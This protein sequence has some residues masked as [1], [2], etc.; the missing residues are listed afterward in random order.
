MG[1]SLADDDSCDAALSNFN[2][3]SLSLQAKEISTSTTSF[4]LVLRHT[5]FV[6]LFGF[7]ACRSL[8]SALG[9]S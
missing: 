8:S 7:S 9:I 2:F 4:E 5:I 6:Y 3:K 1:K